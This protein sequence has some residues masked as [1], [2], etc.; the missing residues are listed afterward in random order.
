MKREKESESSP[1]DSP[2][3]TV[4]FI[5]LV[6]GGEDR[7]N[8]RKSEA[9]KSGRFGKSEY[10]KSPFWSEPEYLLKKSA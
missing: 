5:S 6:K 8:G 1:G 10:L 4:S 2:G 7:V 3:K 9:I